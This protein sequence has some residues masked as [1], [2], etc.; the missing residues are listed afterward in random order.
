A[1]M[2][3]AVA[4]PTSTQPTLSRT[5][6]VA[7]LG[8][9]AVLAALPATPV[10][11]AHA[12][13]QAGFANVIPASWGDELVAGAALRE[14]SHF[15]DGPAVHCS[16][17]IVAHRLLTVG[18]DLRP[19]L[20]ALVPPPVAV[21]RYL[22][23]LSRPNRIRVTYVGSCPGAVDDSIDIRMTPD[24]LIAMLA[25]RQIVIDEQPLVFESV[26]PSDRRR[27]QSQPGGLPAADALWNELG[28]RTLIE[29]GGD[30]L[31]ADLAQHLLSGRNV[32]IDAS[33]RLGCYCSGAVDS[34]AP[35]HARANVVAV[36]PP[37]SPTPVV[38]ENA[39]IELYSHVPAA[40]RT[41]IDV[42][43]VRS[44]AALV[45]LTTPARGVDAPFGNR[46]SPVRGVA[47]LPEPRAARTS[48]PGMTRPVQVIV[49]VSRDVAGR[50]LPRA[51]VARRRSSPRGMPAIVAPPP[52][53]LVA[54]PT[55]APQT[56]GPLRMPTSVGDVVREL[57]ARLGASIG[58]PLR[59]RHLLYGLIGA[60]AVVVAVSAA[61]A[62]IVER[63]ISTPPAAASTLR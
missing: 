3:L 54:L 31:V 26:I 33:V 41:P 27:F 35:A 23:A 20:V 61:V 57:P 8:T 37:R 18:G 10:Q 14:L 36:E 43:A 22:H 55:P 1:P 44:G 58:W 6:P 29:V 60:L 52:Q 48:N 53:P 30:D 13:L 49:P 40:S 63:S 56:D 25:E 4:D 32:L 45:T 39:P 42:A 16:C 46:I 19:V 7:I 5:V 24:A 34:V 12:C 59:R 21:S 9:D 51:Y 38:E 11:L 50:S 2:T 15:G 28:S 62:V 17:P 47:T